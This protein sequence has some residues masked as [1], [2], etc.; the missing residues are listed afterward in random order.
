MHL[1]HSSDSLA[2]LLGDRLALVKDE[3]W[4]LIA[5]NEDLHCTV[6]LTVLASEELKL[7]VRTLWARF[8]IT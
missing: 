6:E 3:E 8:H 7:F 5:G 2:S 4:V 1:T